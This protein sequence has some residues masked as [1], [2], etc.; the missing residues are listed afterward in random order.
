MACDKS[1]WCAALWLSLNRPLYL[2]LAHFHDQHPRSQAWSPW[3]LFPG[4]QVEPPRRL[5]SL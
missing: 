5:A 4:R 1:P 2:S 3:Y